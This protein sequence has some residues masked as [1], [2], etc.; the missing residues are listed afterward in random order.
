MSEKELRVRDK[1]QL[2]IAVA[3][4]KL[5]GRA[6]RMAEIEEPLPARVDGANQGSSSK[7]LA[8]WRVIGFFFPGFRGMP[9]NL[10]PG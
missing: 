3:Q 10:R 2:A 5:S 6:C 9:A 8:V 1:L 7:F 4:G